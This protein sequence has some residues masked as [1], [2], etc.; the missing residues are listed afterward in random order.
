MGQDRETPIERAGVSEWLTHERAFALILAAATAIAIYLCFEIVRPF[1]PAIA[2]ALTL[3]VAI[4][5]VHARIERRVKQPSLAAALTVVLVAAII[6]APALFVAE[7]LAE[8]TAAAIELFKGELEVKGLAGIVGDGSALGSAINWVEAN[9]D[10]SAQLRTLAVESLPRLS[11]VVTG[12]IWM[13]LQLVVMLFTLFFLLRDRCVALERF[14]SLMPMSKFEVDRIIVRVRDTLH[15]TVIG[16]VAVSLIQGALTGLA[17]WVLGL[18]APLLWAAVGAILG[19]FPV[20]GTFMVWIP[21]S[22]WFALNGEIGKAVILAAWGATVVSFI[23]NMLYPVLVGGEM[24]LHTAQ[25]FFAVAGGLLLFGASGVIL[26]PIVLAITISL[27]EI[28][29]RRLLPSELDDTGEIEKPAPSPE[30]RK[31]M[32]PNFS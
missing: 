26:G 12:S 17:F 6:I 18:P 30:P 32:E 13:A 16:T 19:F 20:L 27:L 28:W 23:D 4:F 24:R 2:W 10:V 1:V 15:A 14:R 8:Q 5:P 25:V 3:A 7:Q 9:Y 22:I 31:S 21:A 11:R 29:R